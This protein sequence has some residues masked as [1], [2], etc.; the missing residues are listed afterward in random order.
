MGFYGKGNLNF[1][2]NFKTQNKQECISKRKYPSGSRLY[3]E[4]LKLNQSHMKKKVYI[5]V[6]LLFIFC[7]HREFLN[8]L[9][10]LQ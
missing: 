5:P 3:L 7:L 9:V 4:Q 8:Q 2:V 1:L 6:H 10:K